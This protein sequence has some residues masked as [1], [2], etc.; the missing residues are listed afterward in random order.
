M[1]PLVTVV[2]A[3]Y[4]SD[5][6][7]SLLAGILFHSQVAMPEVEIERSMGHTICRLCLSWSGFI[8]GLTASLVTYRLFLHRCRKFPGPGLAKLTRFHAAYLN[9]QEEQFYEKLGAMHERYGDFVRVGPREVSILNPA[10]IPVLY[11]PKTQCTRS[12]FYTFSGDRDDITNLNGVRDPANC[13]PRRRAWD[14]GMSTKGMHQRNALCMQPRIKSQVDEL[15]KQL[16]SRQGQSIDVT[17]WSLFYSFDT[18]GS[19]GFR[20]DFGNMI[21]GQEHPALQQMH[22]HLWM[23]GVLQAIPWLPN[24]LSGL[25]EADRSIK[26]FHDL[27][28]NIL[29]EKQKSYD[30]NTEPA[31]VVS[32]LLKAFYEKDASASPTTLSLADDNRAFIVAGNDTTANTL[33]NARLYLA[34][35][36]DIHQKLRSQLDA[37]LSE[38]YSSWDYGKVMSVSYIDDIVNETLR[39]KPP[40][41]QG[42]PRETPPQG[43]YIAGT[44]VPGHVIASVR[45]ILIQ[46]DPRWWRDPNKFIPERFGEKRE[47]MGTDDSPWIPF[48]LENGEKFDGDFLASFMMVLRPLNLVFTSRSAT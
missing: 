33:A 4:T 6:Q 2:Q 41:I 16:V 44:Y 5:F 31:D 25:P 29:T 15:V 43:V 27:H 3:S 19:V 21:L 10:A 11:G 40:V 38:D 23:L 24:L 14:R 39:L 1:Y 17:K 32:W 45:I 8:V 22:E 47:E 34:K 13:R 18:M 26:G 36:Q 30:D 42:L 7:A 20:K 35:H 46:R 28:N 12:T 37:A 48:Q 9:A